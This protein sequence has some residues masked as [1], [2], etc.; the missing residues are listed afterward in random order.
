MLSP[1]LS[2]AALPQKWEPRFPAC[3]CDSQRKLSICLG[4]QEAPHCARTT[5]GELAAHEVHPIRLAR[6]AVLAADHQQ[7]S[8]HLDV[9]VLGV[10]AE[11][12]NLAVKFFVLVIELNRGVNL[13]VSGCPS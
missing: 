2:S 11:P 6:M 12:E 10:H 7:V 4:L 5:A 9:D 13:A 1:R 3:R 8:E